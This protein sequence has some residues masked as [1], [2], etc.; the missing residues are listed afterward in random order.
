MVESRRS[1]ASRPGLA[2]PHPVQLTDVAPAAQEGAQGGWRLDRAAQDAGR[3][4]GAQRIGVVGSRRPPARKRPASVSCRVGP[5]RRD[6]QVEVMVDEF[7]QAQVMGEGGRSPALATRRW[8]GDTDAVGWLPVAGARA[9]QNHYP[10]FMHPLGA[11]PKALL[12]WIRAKPARSP[13]PDCSLPR[14]VV[15]RRRLRTYAMTATIAK[16]APAPIRAINPIGGPSSGSG[17]EGGGGGAA[18]WV[19]APQWGWGL[20]SARAPAWGGYRLR[21]RCAVGSGSAWL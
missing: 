7:P 12:R 1:G 9:V 20:P 15:Y 21:R 10:R 16:T 4:T 8:S 13:I 5:P 19:P 17:A 18:V 6:A 3:P 14:T 2:V 11:V